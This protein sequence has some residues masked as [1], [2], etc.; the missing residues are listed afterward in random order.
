MSIA[1]FFRTWWRGQLVGEDSQGNKYYEDRKKKR[2]G[3]PRRWVIYKGTA[4]A[5]K[6]PAPWHGW[7]HYI[8]QAPSPSSPIYS[9][10]KE[11]SPN[12]TGTPHAHK[13]RGKRGQLPNKGYEAWTPENN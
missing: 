8:T 13:P 10:E 7:L 2:Y 3:K 5:S 11:H 6:I 4:E 12:L 9:C 1:I